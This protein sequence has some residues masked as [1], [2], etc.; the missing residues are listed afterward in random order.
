M[1]VLLKMDNEKRK[2]SKGE[3]MNIKGEKM[4]VNMT[5][6]IGWNYGLPSQTYISVNQEGIANS[7]EAQDIL[8]NAFQLSEDKNISVREALISVL[9][10]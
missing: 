9:N 8:K 2:K 10:G 5:D 3:K 6:D 7:F 1:I 4:N